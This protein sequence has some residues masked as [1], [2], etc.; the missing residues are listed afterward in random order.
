MKGLII[1]KKFDNFGNA[2]ELY[3]TQIKWRYSDNSGNAYELTDFIDVREID[4][5]QQK[6]IKM[7]HQFT[8]ALEAMSIYTIQEKYEQTKKEDSNDEILENSPAVDHD[9]NSSGD[10]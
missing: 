6:T 8:M 2:V 3:P 5:E 10:D 1:N 7:I 9:I 4:H